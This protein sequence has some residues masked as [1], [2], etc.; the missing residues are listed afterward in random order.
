[1]KLLIFILLL[2]GFSSCQ[3]KTPRTPDKPTVLVSIVPYAYFVDRIAQNLVNIEILVPKGADPHVYEPTPKQVEA[4]H[5]AKL[6]VRIGEPFEEKVLKALQTPGSSLNSLQMWEKLPLLSS[7][8]CHEHH[9][10]CEEAEDLHVWMSPKLAK[11]QAARIKD[12]LCALLPHQT[13]ELEQNLA[14]FLEDLNKLD[15]EI[16]TKLSPLKD[17]AILVS[18]PAFGYFCRDY[19]LQQLSLESEGKEAL[20]QTVMETLK[21]AEKARVRCIITQSQYSNKAAELVAKKLQLP[22]FLND[23]YAGDYLENL[24]TLAETLAETS[25]SN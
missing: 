6:W 8:H 19:H 25:S 23:P 9:G 2:F 15:Q 3:D 5:S 24:R 10:R 1:M 21:K 4:A 7:H 20:P 13:A 14:L 16:Q 11:I 18:H 22:I 17:Q 12:S